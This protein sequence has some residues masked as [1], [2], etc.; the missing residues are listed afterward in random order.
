[1]IISGGG[2]GQKYGIPNKLEILSALSFKPIKTII[3]KDDLVEDLI[4]NE[5]FGYLLANSE[6]SLFFYQFELNGDLTL[7][8]TLS[9]NSD[10][11]EQELKVYSID[12]FVFVYFNNIELKIFNIIEKD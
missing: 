6:K 1:M 10:I 4:S 9:F 7:K 8:E 11:D 2:G 3:F 12:K 5:E